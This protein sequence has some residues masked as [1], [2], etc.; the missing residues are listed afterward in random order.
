M[1]VEPD[2][3]AGDAAGG[4]AAADPRVTGGDALEPASESSSIGWPGAVVVA[5]LVIIIG[6]AGCIIGPN[7]ILTKSLALTRT[8]REWLATALFFAVLVILAV[9]LRTLQQRKII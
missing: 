2:H 5:V 6:F 7:A 3:V 9:A 8:A 1:S 4:E